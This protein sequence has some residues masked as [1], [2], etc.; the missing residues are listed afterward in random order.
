MLLLLLLLPAC[1]HYPFAKNTRPDVVLPGSIWYSP[2]GRRQW[3]S[4]QAPD[5]PQLFVSTTT[6]TSRV[7]PTNIHVRRLLP[8]L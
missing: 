2:S 4:L 3:G 6:F 8:Y 1:A 7:T 5:G